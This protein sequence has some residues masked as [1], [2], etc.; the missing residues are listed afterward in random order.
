M[1]ASPAALAGSAPRGTKATPRSRL[2]ATAND[3]G[4]ERLARERNM[5]GTSRKNPNDGAEAGLTSGSP[6]PSRPG[7]ADARGDRETRSWL[8]APQLWPAVSSGPR[9]QPG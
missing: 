2:T 8:V 1:S 5:E 6:R 4:S 7:D 3:F 9:R